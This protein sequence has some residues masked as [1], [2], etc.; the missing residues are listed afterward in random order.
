MYVPYQALR[1]KRKQL[2]WGGQPEK[3]SQV[4]QVAGIDES[5]HL[6]CSKKPKQVQPNRAT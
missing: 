5:G 6:L 3:M 2:I 1:F 4:I